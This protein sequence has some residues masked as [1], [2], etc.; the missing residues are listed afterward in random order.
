MQGIQ[1]IG[2]NELK[3]FVQDLQT[4][5]SWNFDL[6]KS[7]YLICVFFSPCCYLGSISKKVAAC[8]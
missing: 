5:L 8:V 2:L 4:I 6:R 7:D 1:V 3:L